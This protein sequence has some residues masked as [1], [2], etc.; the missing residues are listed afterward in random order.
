MTFGEGI[1]EII[2]LRSQDLRVIL[3]WTEAR[4]LQSG[5]LLSIK[6]TITIILVSLSWGVHPQNSSVW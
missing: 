5:Q 1:E 3:D 6:V 4:L 2:F